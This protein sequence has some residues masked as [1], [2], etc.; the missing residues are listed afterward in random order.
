MGI[1]PAPYY[2]A[3]LFLGWCEYEFLSHLFSFTIIRPAKQVRSAFRFTNRYLDDL[4]A[5]HNKH[6]DSLLF[7]TPN[8]NLPLGVHGIYPS[9]LEIPQQSHPEGATP[10]LDILLIHSV[11][12]GCSCYVTRLFDKLQQSARAFASISRAFASFG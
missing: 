9:Q 7:R 1:S 6:L 4:L 3:N 11:R 10:F 5:L 8:V 12:N 2:I